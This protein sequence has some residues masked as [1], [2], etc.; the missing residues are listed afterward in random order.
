MGTERRARQKANRAKKLE[1]Q[2]QADRRDQVRQYII[3]GVVVALGIAGLVV[4]LS[5]GGDDDE[6][7]TETTEVTLATT[8]ST[9]P[10]LESAISAPDPGG[11]IDG[12]PECPPEDGSAE[13]VTVFAEAPPMCIDPEATYTAD[14]ETTL[15]TITVELDAAAAPNT[16]NNFVFLARYRFYEGVPFHRIVQDFVIQA[17]SPAEPL[18]A[19]GPGYTFADELP[20]DGEYEVGSLA[21]ANSGPDTNGSQFFILTSETGAA[22]LPAQ[23]SLFGS[24]TDGL[25]VALDIE[26]I[27]T[28]PNEQPSEEIYIESI[29]ITES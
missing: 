10:P 1:E 23:Y 3:I 21:M 15:G 26:A 19:T 27:P 5:L 9:E 25:D 14:I 18:G 16:V 6:V 11:E 2:Q 28:A 17:G 13:R 12:T 4:L 7:A 22:N 20:E 29:T 8:T 24:V